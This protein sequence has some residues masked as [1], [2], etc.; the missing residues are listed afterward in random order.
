MHI[1]DNF[2]LTAYIWMTKLA[3]LP[4]YNVYFYALHQNIK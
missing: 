2:L 4:Q 3:M 1:I